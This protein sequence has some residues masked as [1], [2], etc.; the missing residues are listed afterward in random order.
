MHHNLNFSLDVALH[1][2]ILFT[3]LTIFFF[4]YVSKLEKQTLDNT[5]INSVSDNTNTLLNDI[6]QISQKYNIKINW[7]NINDIAAKLVKNSKGEVPEIKENNDRLYKGSM[8]AIIVGYLLF[9]AIVIFLKYYMGYDI[10]IRHILL[11]NIII[12]SITGLI[13]YFFFMN[14]ASKY[15]PVMPNEISDTM[16]ERI[17]YNFNN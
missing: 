16:L 7:N 10:H 14:V 17:K 6:K 2:L 12:F 5:I 3:F 8:I 1:V 13:E 9:L 15:V 11:M 4:T